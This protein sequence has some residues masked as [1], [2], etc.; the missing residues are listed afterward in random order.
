MAGRE[1][2]SLLAKGP[3]C[4]F[5]DRLSQREDAKPYLEKLREGLLSLKNEGYEDSMGV[6][7]SHLL[8]EFPEIKDKIKSIDKHLRTKWFDEEDT[9]WWPHLQP[10]E[11]VFC[12][13]IVKA[14]D[15]S[16]G[17]KEDRKGKLFPIDSYWIV[18]EDA[19]EMTVALGVQQVNLFFMTPGW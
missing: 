18:V 8:G 15:L 16:I 6:F 14:L 10:I 3:L 7:K 13:G 4:Y 1:L 5:L 17:D 11:P 12:T 19:F 2:G 9:G